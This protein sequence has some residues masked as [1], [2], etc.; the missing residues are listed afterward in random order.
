MRAF[1]CTSRFLLLLNYLIKQCPLI[2]IRKGSIIPAEKKVIG[3]LTGG[4]D[5]PGLNAVIRGVTVKAISLGYEVLGF[6]RG[7]KGLLGKG[8]TQPLT[9]A[10]VENIQML[11]GTILGTSRTNPYKMEGAVA[12]VKENLKKF[13]IECLV[14]IGGEDTLGVAWK[15]HNEGVKVVGVP[16]TIDNDV[17]ATD[18]TFGFDT[19]INIA[20]E[21]LDR[22]HTTAQ[23]HDRVLV[24]EIMGRHA[25]W[26]TLHVGIAG[27]AHVIIIPEEKY[28]IA[29]I[30][31]VIMAREKAG[32]HYSIVAI[33]EGAMPKENEEVS[34]KSGE[35][36]AFGH[37]RLG[38]AAENLAK[39]IE[40]RTGKESRAVI[41]GHLQ[42]G[43]APSAFD[44]VIGTRF[45]VHAAKMVCEKQYGKIAALRGTEIVTAG[46]QE[47]LGT[48]KTVPKER[49][50]E[51]KIF[52]EKGG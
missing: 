37:V 23:S 43:G 10:N 51:A 40:K 34:S 39:E 44:R 11:G 42:R 4:G 17:N 25:G 5:A 28:D 12:E 52:F 21:A 50:E 41:L 36:D 7:W 8:E 9:L 27:G 48:L 2:L 38:G 19:A 35:K 22:L 6:R 47:A 24:V 13:N 49:L 45:G 26:L 33:A 30:C 18:F 20:T 15:L 32:K 46:M 3:I 16:K 1:S 29:E 31:K 14:A